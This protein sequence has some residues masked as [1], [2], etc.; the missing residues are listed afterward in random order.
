METRS[1]FGSQ[2]FGTTKIRN[3]NEDSYASINLPLAIDA[4]EHPIAIEFQFVQPLVPRW[5]FF[6]K[7]SGLGWNEGSSFDLR[8]PGIFLMSGLGIPLESPSIC[9]EVY[10]PPAEK[11]SSRSFRAVTRSIVCNEQCLIEFETTSEC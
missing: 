3:D 11:P 2:N 6:H 8:A 9:D 5:W 10:E 1:N 7:G 4:T